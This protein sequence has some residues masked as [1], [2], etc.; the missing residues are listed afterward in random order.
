HLHERAHLDS[1]RAHVDD[2]VRDPKM[3]FGARVG[4]REQDAPLRDVRERRPHLLAVDDVLVAVA[5]GTRGEAGEVAARA[6]LAEQLAPEFGAVEKTWQPS[7]A[8][9]FG[10]GDEQRRARP[11][12]TDRIHRPRYT[13]LSQDFVDL[14]LLRR[15][16]VETPRLG[17]VRH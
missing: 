15:G 12:D 11:P 14:E 5:D 13:Q 6:R 16:C 3:L 7:P 4:A 9:L 10:A 17:P 8:L 1:W 2:E